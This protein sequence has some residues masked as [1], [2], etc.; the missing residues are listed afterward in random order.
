MDRKKKY[1]LVKKI[2]GY[3]LIILYHRLISG[4]FYGVVLISY[5][6][7]LKTFTEL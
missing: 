2:D 3:V 7:I 6:H 4:F 5:K 1:K